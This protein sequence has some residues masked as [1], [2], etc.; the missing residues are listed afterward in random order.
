MTSGFE[1]SRATLEQLSLVAPLYDAYR[2]FYGQ[3][4]DIDLATRFLTE[5]FR[6]I[7]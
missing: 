1:I 2:Q 6:T 4:S 5:R 7:F 3:A